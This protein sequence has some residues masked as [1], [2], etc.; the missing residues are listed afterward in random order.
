M[1]N[2]PIYPAFAF[3]LF[4]VKYKNAAKKSLFLAKCIFSE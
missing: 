1:Q 3:Y 2:F 4:F